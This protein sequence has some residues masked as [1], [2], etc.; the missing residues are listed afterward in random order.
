MPKATRT[1]HPH[2]V[3]VPG[4]CGG[5]PNHR[6]DA[7]QRGFHRAL[8]Q[9]WRKAWEIIVAY[10]HLKPAAVYDAISYYL[11]HQEEIEQEIAASTPEVPAAKLGFE[12]GDDGRLVFKRP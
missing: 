8:P 9:S 12:V 10:P 3:I 5:R 11:D 2:I 1:E 4:I 7:H 6:R